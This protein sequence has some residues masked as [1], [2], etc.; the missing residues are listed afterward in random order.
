M[1]TPV[2]AALP[3][4]GTTYLVAEVTVESGSALAGRTVAQAE[5]AYGARIATC[6]PKATGVPEVPGADMQI[7]EGDRLV[8]HVAAGKLTALSAAAKGRQEVV[9]AKS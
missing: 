9:S 1:D 3:I 7:R 8:I 2:L 4:A 5:A 6:I